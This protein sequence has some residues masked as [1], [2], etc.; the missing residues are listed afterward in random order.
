M[1][2]IVERPSSAYKDILGAVYEWDAEGS[3]LFDGVV[4][5]HFTSA[6]ESEALVYAEYC[7]PNEP[8][9]AIFL[10]RVN[11]QW[12]VAW[13]D[14]SLNIFHCGAV[15]LPNQ[16]ELL[17]CR[18]RSSGDGVRRQHLFTIDFSK[19]QGQRRQVFLTTEDTLLTRAPVGVLC[20]LERGAFTQFFHVTVRR[21]LL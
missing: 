13:S 21:G 17:I 12:K 14:S 11:R 20:N 4:E 2:E 9:T 10:Q 15:G 6:L 8:E 5:G 18:D 3:C 19:P 7:S 16:L 1:N